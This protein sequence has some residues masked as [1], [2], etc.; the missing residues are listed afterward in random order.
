[1]PGINR[2]Q[3]IP[4]LRFTTDNKKDDTS[5]KLGEKNQSGKSAQSGGM[6][7]KMKEE[8]YESDLMGTMGYMNTQYQEG[9]GLPIENLIL[10]DHTLIKTVYEK[11]KSCTSKEE[12]EK[13]R[14]ELV[15]EIARHSIA[16]E[17]VLYPL[18]RKKL[19]EGESLFQDSIKEHHEV[20]EN[21]SRAKNGIRIMTKFVLFYGFELRN[22]NSSEGREQTCSF[23]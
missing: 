19:P 14:N 1:M 8:V 15:Y 17:I 13:W 5:S 2:L 20:K 22:L 10:Q 16:E 6:A 4:K 11:F 12:A 18:M 21:L 23:F 9:F 7:Q 3:L